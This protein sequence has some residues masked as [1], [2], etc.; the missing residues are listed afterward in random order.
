MGHA[1]GQPYSQQSTRAAG[2]NSLKCDSPAGCP[3]QVDIVGCEDIG[4]VPPEA[5]GFQ[6]MQPSTSLVGPVPL[7]GLAG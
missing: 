3:S 5:V 4:T 7:A 1:T 6:L 2:V